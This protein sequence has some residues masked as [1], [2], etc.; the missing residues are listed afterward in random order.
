MFGDDR[1]TRVGIAGDA[2]TI[3]GE[4]TYAGQSFQ[5]HSIE[6]RLFNARMIQALFDDEN[7]DTV[8][9]WAYPD[10]GE[11]N[12]ER[13]VAEFLAAMPAWYAHGLRAVTVNLQCG[14]PEGYSEEQP[15][16]VSAF[17]PDGTL[18]DAWLARLRRVLDRA[19]SLGMVVILGLF[20]FGQDDVLEDESAVVTAVDNAVTWLLDQEYTNVVLEVNNECDINYDHDILG[21]DRVPELIERIHEMER[22]GYRYHVATSFSGNHVPT[23]EVIGVSDYV[24]MHGNGV[25]DPDRIREMVREVRGAPSYQPKPIVFNEDDHFCFGSDS[26]FAAAIEAGASWGY[27]DPGENDYVHGYQCP[28]VEWGINTARK[29]AFFGYL[30]GVTSTV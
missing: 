30:D 22:D 20:Y 6:G 2:F 19:D 28:P 1:E 13:N 14:S 10:T 21:A 23:N 17:E 5:G 12:P 15:W 18:K 27:F 29:K 3:N 9:N 16:V 24:L 4:P 26:N 11:Y 8:D 7:P 25:N